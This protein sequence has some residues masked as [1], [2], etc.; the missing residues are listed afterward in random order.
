MQDDTVTSMWHNLSTRLMLAGVLIAVVYF[1]FAA[2]SNGL[3]THRLHQD[4]AQIRQEIEELKDD[5]RLLSSL[6]E[7]LNS[8]EYIESVARQQLGLVRPGETPISVLPSAN[9]EQ[10]DPSPGGPWWEAYLQR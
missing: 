10:K 3:Q 6:Q 5:Y 8:D 1:L 9:Q 4:E 7:Y 2:V